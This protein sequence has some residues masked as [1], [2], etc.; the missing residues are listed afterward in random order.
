VWHEEGMPLKFRVTSNTESS[1]VYELSQHAQLYPEIKEMNSVEMI[2][3]TLD[4]IVPLNFKP[5]FIN[6]DIQG[7]ELNALKGF[8]NRL[9][10]V[11]AIYLE[12]NKSDLYFG[13]PLFDEINTFLEYKGF[14]LASVKWWKLDGWGDALF[15]RSDVRMNNQVRRFFFRKIYIG[16]WQL[17]N[18]IRI[19]L[20]R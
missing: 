1:S 15:L 12:V 17:K 4:S 9:L 14:S 16:V 8:G 20:N 7:S 6:L 11:E 5:T 13:I 10:K 3:T 18:F 19:I 2:S